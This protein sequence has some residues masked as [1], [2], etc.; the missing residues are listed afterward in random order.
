[1]KKEERR[2]KKEEKMDGDSQRPATSCLQ[3]P[4]NCKHRVDGRVLNP[5]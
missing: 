1:M 4:T 3:S 5:K 2:N